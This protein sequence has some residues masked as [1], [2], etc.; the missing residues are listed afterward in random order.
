MSWCQIDDIRSLSLVSNVITI[1]NGVT[2]AG[3]TALTVGETL[4]LTAMPVSQPASATATAT[5]VWA[6]PAGTGLTS[7]SRFLSQV[8]VSANMSGLYTV[9]ATIGSCKAVGTTSVT[10]TGARIVTG[11]LPVASVCFS[12]ELTVPFSQTGILATNA[13][14]ATGLVA[15]L[16][17]AG[18]SFNQPTRLSTLGSTATSMQVALPPTLASSVNYR[19][20]VISINPLIEGTVSPSALT[21]TSA[22]TLS[23]SVA[24]PA[25]NLADG[26]SVTL[27][28]RLTPAT[29][30]ATYAWRTPTGTTAT[31]AT[32]IVPFSTATA[33][34]LY[35]LTATA[36]GGCTVTGA[37]AL[38][39]S[40]QSC[41]VR[42]VA[43]DSKGKET[44]KIPR[45]AP[46]S[47]TLSVESLE[48]ALLQGYT[49]QWF[50]KTAAG[51]STGLGSSLS[52]VATAVGEYGVNLT[53][54]D[55]STCVAYLTL[56]RTLCQTVV[57]TYQCGTNPATPVGTPG[58]PPLTNLA[59]GDT[60][61]TG[62][63]DVVVT[64][65]T[66]GGASGWTGKGYTEIP[67]L[68]NQ[69]IA[70]ELNGAVV[71]DCYELVSGT[72]VS[73]YDPAWG[74]V[75]DINTANIGADNDD[76]QTTL[77]KVQD[78]MLTFSGSDGD[79]QRIDEYI[80]K[81]QTQILNDPDLTDEQ[82]SQGLADLT[83][84][85]K[86]WEDLKACSSARMATATA[87]LAAP[88]CSKETVSDAFAQIN[89]TLTNPLTPCQAPD[90][91]RPTRPGLEGQMTTTVGTR[92]GGGPDGPKPE[93]CFKEWYYFAGAPASLQAATFPSI[94][95]WSAGWYSKREYISRVREVI[96]A[97]AYLTGDVKVLDPDFNRAQ[98]LALFNDY[99]NSRSFSDNFLT[100]I[101][102][103]YEGIKRSI[104]FTVTGSGAIEP[105]NIDF[106]VLTVGT[107]TGWK[108]LAQASFGL[109]KAGL[110]SSRNAYITVRLAANL[111]LA[112][113]GP[114]GVLSNIK[115]L[116]KNI[117]ESSIAHSM[118]LTN[119]PFINPFGEQV[120]G[121]LL[122]IK[123]KDNT[124]HTL[125]GIRGD[126]TSPLG[127]VVRLFDK[128]DYL[129][130]LTIRG[131]ILQ[132]VA[133]P[134]DSRTVKI[135]A[136]ATDNEIIQLAETLAGSKLSNATLREIP[137][138]KIWTWYPDPS[139]QKFQI[140][141]RNLGNLTNQALTEARWTIDVVNENLLLSVVNDKK[142]EL[143]FQ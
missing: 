11:T 67:Y 85:K 81:L 27:S 109:A 129:N 93:S 132:N 142:I 74:E 124:W 26:S 111:R 108:A 14:T 18:G 40:T 64:E 31:S 125:S 32:L 51:V 136:G 4:S 87:R 61:R 70:V 75:R 138:G 76:P 97:F 35:T 89:T 141:L 46:A 56:S 98:S 42:I 60:I 12:R 39:T 37:T 104:D 82:R 16:S 59:P 21:I 20:R 83:L 118:Q 99:V 52:V 6:G 71:N 96:K 92:I 107:L 113:I 100:T 66:G 103:D 9:T 94:S 17:D 105:F 28:A 73:A 30:E 80:A 116:E 84:A 127:D 49:Y 90:A 8:G 121:R 36:P 25:G 5:Y 119:Q 117:T 38:T 72:V 53:G 78:A 102:A 126:I 63:F 1:Q 128:T 50:Y 22:P 122:L 133:N 65:V 69:R 41:D 114:G 134:R 79:K 115:W 54:P 23:V 62:D 106:D 123:L 34:A 91:P 95:D 120:V 140:R 33:T 2:I 19:V 130:S 13:T 43:K 44:T 7:T 10:V 88:A 139:N 143:K 101:S 86:A 137:Q 77:A 110:L 68:K 55:A 131:K 48:G 57:Q 47:L 3:V 135:F 24:Y 58:S 112:K 29:P 45:T 15:E